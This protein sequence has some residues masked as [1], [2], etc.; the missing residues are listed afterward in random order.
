MC[1]CEMLGSKV[2]LTVCCGIDNNVLLVA[3]WAL[4]RQ[5]DSLCCSQT[6]LQVTSTAV[7]SVQTK[8]PAC[9]V[10][11]CKLKAQALA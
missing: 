4:H 6:L 10:L 2:H 1:V 5:L 11:R 8:L 9:S 3:C 7:H